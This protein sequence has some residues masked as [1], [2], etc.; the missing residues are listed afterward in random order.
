M[1]RAS[2][3]RSNNYAVTTATVQTTGATIYGQPNIVA[4]NQPT[5]R[6][7]VSGNEYYDP[8]PKYTDELPSYYESLGQTNK[9]YTGTLPASTAAVPA[10][11][12][13]AR[14]PEF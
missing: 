8:P 1:R 13:Q 9:A 6:T 14:A 7:N 2:F 12:I 11:E 5:Y 3:P 10:S 4:N